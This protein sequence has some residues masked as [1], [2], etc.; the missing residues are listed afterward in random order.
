MGYAEGGMGAKSTG[1]YGGDQDVWGMAAD[2]G[3]KAKRKS[4]AP[5]KST[6]VDR[7]STQH[8][9]M[10]FGQSGQGGMPDLASLLKKDSSDEYSQAAISDEDSGLSAAEDSELDEHRVSVMQNQREAA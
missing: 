9:T 10:V 6:A 5:R 7:K 1:A 8:T 4:M 3:A 2:E